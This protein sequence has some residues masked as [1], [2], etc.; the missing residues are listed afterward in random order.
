MT[1]S[2]EVFLICSTFL[3]PFVVSLLPVAVGVVSS[4]AV[5]EGDA[6]SIAVERSR[7]VDATT[8]LEKIGVG[9]RRCGA[10]K[11]LAMGNDAVIIIIMTIIIDRADAVA[12]VVVMDILR[13]PIIAQGHDGVARVRLR[14]VD[15]EEEKL[16]G[17]SVKQTF[18]PTTKR[19]SQIANKKFIS[20]R[21][22]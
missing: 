14:C 12:M 2:R 4:M 17:S 7:V 8:V 19:Q 3:L 15:V 10:A 18:T 11:A 21:P 20:S 6:S 16:F 13:R 9:R 1:S 22:R 5:V